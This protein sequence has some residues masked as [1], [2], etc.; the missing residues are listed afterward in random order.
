[1][2]IPNA[3]VAS[4]SFLVAFLLLASCT[5]EVLTYRQELELVLDDIRKEIRDKNV[6]ALM[7][8]I[9]TD[10]L[11]EAGRRRREILLL[12]QFRFRQHQAIYFLDRVGELTIDDEPQARVRLAVAVAG[13]PIESIDGLV[14][15][16]ADLFE[17][18]V[19]F[20]R[21]DDR[22]WR[23]RAITWQRIGIEDFF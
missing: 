9:D 14:G 11:D 15:L 18:T 5:G 23:V 19:K 1:M 13:R 17:F 8:R 6:A 7:D 2:S 10:Y 16:R 12:M 3:R 22:D 21:Y 20:K 4:L